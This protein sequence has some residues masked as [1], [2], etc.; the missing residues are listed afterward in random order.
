MNWVSWIK[1]VEMKKVPFKRMKGL[2][3]EGIAC[4]V[5]MC[6]KIHWISP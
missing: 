1:A 2:Q 5:A 6:E 4:A 3:A